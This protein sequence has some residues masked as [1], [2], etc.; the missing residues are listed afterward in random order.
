MTIRETARKIPFARKVYRAIRGKRTAPS[1][2]PEDAP[3]LTKEQLDELSPD[4]R[5]DYYIKSFVPERV[6]LEV[7]TVCQ[8]RCAGC[9]FQKGGEDD[10]ER[11]FLSLE[12]FKNF[13]NRNPFVREI[14]I[15]NYGEPFLNP[16]LAKMMHYAKE[17]GI[18]LVCRNG[19]NFNT[20]SDEQIRAL[21]DT[22]FEA[23]T[24]SIDGASQEVYEKYRIGGDF[25]RVIENV[26][27]LQAY[28]KEKGSKL[29]KLKWQYILMEHNELEIGK[30]KAL[31]KELGIPIHFKLNWDPSY[32]PVHREYLIEET[33]LKELTEAE[34]SATHK[35][36]AFNSLCEQMFIRPQ[37]NWDGRLLGCCT[38]RYATFDVNVFEVG[39]IEAIR[40]P[41]YI[42]NKECLMTVHPDKER[43]SSC[44]CYSCPTR[45]KREESGIAFKI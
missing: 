8:L 37:V 19:S 45:L 12:N 35:V 1:K 27:K 22:G 13:C 14:E 16:H 2:D 6:R 17:K 18:T 42:L 40:S 4:E 34:Y 7:S 25:D 39:L 33:G 3:R 23:I 30:A 11:G 28:K 26:K 10:L 36:S 31:A 9:G 43:F 32:E 29:P 15:S 24:L 41:K 5:R 21:V 44:T 20:I 38:R